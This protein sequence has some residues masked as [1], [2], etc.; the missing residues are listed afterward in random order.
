MGSQP[1]ELYGKSINEIAERCGVSLKTAGRWKA[2]T[3][4][5]P[6]SALMILRRDLGIFDPA[7]KGWRVRGGILYSP[8]GWEIPVGDVLAIPLERRQLA[9]AYAEVR[10]LKAE[11]Y[12]GEQPLPESWPEHKLN[13]A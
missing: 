3:T 9:N 6:E 10:R 13:I 5:P 7:W 8:E 12:A 2:G 4:C 1:P 11:L